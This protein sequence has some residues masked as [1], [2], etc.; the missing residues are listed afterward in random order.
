MI[1]LSKILLYNKYSILYL[2]NI[3]FCLNI[4]LSDTVLYNSLIKEFNLIQLKKGINNIYPQF[5][6]EVTV[7]M[8]VLNDKYKEL[9]EVNLVYQIGLKRTPLCIEYVVI[10][11]NLKEKVLFKCPFN[12]GF[13]SIS[14]DDAKL[15]NQ[16]AKNDLYIE[17]YLIDF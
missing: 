8:R 7:N 17:L 11:M 12:M 10:N 4:I 16:D 1:I 5:G 3:I 14:I 2:L 6:D 9:S 13:K 15:S